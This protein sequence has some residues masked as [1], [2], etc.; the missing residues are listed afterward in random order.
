MQEYRKVER[1]TLT[2]STAL[3]A[4]VNTKIESKDLSLLEGKDR[5]NA[6]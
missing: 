5:L 2:S 1:A 3:E 4:K 6:P